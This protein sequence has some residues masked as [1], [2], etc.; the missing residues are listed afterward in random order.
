MTAPNFC[1]YWL[2]SSQVRNQLSAA[3]QQ[4]KIRHTSP[5]KIKACT[6]YIPNLESQ[7]KIDA[8]LRSIE[9]KINQR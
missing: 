4:T 3:A 5:D 1:Y 7:K 6:V 9:E 2:S 8:F